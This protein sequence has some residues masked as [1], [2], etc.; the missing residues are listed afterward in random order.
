MDE[1]DNKLISMLQRDGRASNAHLARLVGVSEG[2]VRRRLKRL[3]QEGIIQVVA[4]VDPQ[5]VGQKTEALVG[6]Q[7]DPN[8]IED[9]AAH[10][11]GLEEIQWVSATTGAYDVFVWVAVASAEELRNFLRQRVGT[12]AGVRRT[13]TFV[14][15]TVRKRAH[16]PS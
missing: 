16:I 6:I 10:L 7:A 12:V 1:L 13:E 5:R 8:K 2:T 15:L 4:V 11:A 3:I 9:V 14:S